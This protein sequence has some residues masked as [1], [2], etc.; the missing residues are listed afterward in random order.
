ME[1]VEVVEGLNKLVI[2]VKAS[3]FIQVFRLVSLMK[4]VA[5]TAF[6]GGFI[7]TIATCADDNEPTLC[8]TVEVSCP[9]PPGEIESFLAAESAALATAADQQMYVRP[10]PIL[11]KP[12]GSKDLV[13]TA[14]VN[15][16]WVPTTQHGCWRLPVHAHLSESG[17]VIT[18]AHSGS[19]RHNLNMFSFRGGATALPE[20]AASARV[21]CRLGPRK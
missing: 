21:Q 9:G 10:V 1:D 19:K 20:T 5:M 18:T 11:Q 6:E 4:L 13:E 14:V 16:K 7:T 8:T 17:H 15:M 12:L 2:K 3:H